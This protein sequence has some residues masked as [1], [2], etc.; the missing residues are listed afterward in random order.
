MRL[1]SDQDRDSFN[2]HDDQ[3]Y[4]LQRSEEGREGEGRGGEGG[5]ERRR[6][7]RGECVLTVR[8]VLLCC[9]KCSG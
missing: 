7:R 5:E 9:T 3:N 2:K 1:L 8:T 4:C 6:E